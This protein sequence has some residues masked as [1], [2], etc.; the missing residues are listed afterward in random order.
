MSIEYLDGIIKLYI[1]R[2]KSRKMKRS[3][4][5]SWCKEASSKR[6]KVESPNLSGR[7]RQ[8]VLVNTSN[9]RQRFD[10]IPQRTVTISE[11]VVVGIWN[12][13]NSL[14][15]LVNRLRAQLEELQ[16]YIRSH[17]IGKCIHIVEHG[18][19]R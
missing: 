11:D 5:E 2:G 12:E 18:V 14:L 8:L 15:S 17:N 7:K 6:K 13:R 19:V 1:S 9:K 4:D 3:R 16:F 10:F